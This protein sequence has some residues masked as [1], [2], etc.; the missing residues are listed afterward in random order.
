MGKLLRQAIVLLLLLTA[1]TGLLY[2][3]AVTGLA[4]LVFPYHANGSLIRRD[5]KPVGSTVIGQSF[6][7]PK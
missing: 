1:I 3:L 6:T 5:G 2:P 7:D 4:Q